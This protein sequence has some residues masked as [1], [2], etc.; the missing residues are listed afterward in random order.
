MA[1]TIFKRRAKL[2]ELYILDLNVSDDTAV[3][4]SMWYWIKHRQIDKNNR[5]YIPETHS[6]IYVQFTTVE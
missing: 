3:I 1:K 2:N 6:L 5:I 4:K